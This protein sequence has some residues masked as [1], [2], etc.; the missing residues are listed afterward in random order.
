MTRVLPRTNFHSSKLIRCL[1]DLTILDAVGPVHSFAE[2]V[3]L[4]IHFT[5]AITLSAVLNEGSAKRAE[6]AFEM[7][8]PVP[9]EGQR[10][11]HGAIAAEFD[12]VQS[13]LISSIIS[14]CTPHLGK[15][16]IEL[17]KPD[18]ELPLEVAAAYAPYRW[19]QDAHQ[20]DMEFRIHP[21]RVNVRA[22]L[23]RA[24]PRLRKLAELD[25]MFERILGDREHH[26]LSKVP[27]LLEKRF[28]QLF[29]AHQQR[30]V[31]P[32][33]DNPADWMQAGAW[34]ARFCS[35][36]QTVLL[37]ESELRLQPTVGLIEALSGSH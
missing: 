31:E 35:D 10:V 15:S 19:F 29:K 23:A 22:A 26:L 2:K 27:I 16:H 33:V 8:L 17:P 30:L 36:M 6:V 7:P 25:A 21:L 12:R 5:D 11:P 34:L 3:G 9:A 28:V 4:W 14:S 20:R 13:G 1:A 37:A 18:L 24:S 32:Q